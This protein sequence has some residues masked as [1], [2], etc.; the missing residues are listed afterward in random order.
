MQIHYLSYP[1]SKTIPVYGGSAS[2]ELIH[3]KVI[4]NGD[5]C[6]TW[7]FCLENHWGTHVDCPAHFFLKGKHVSDFSC[8]FWLFKNPQVIQ[9]DAEPGQIIEARDL[10]EEIP[11]Q[12]DL[13][14]FKSGW[15]QFRGQEIYSFQNPGLHPG[16]G[17]L[18]RKKYPDIRCI[19][20]DWVSVSSYQHRELGREAHRAFLNNSTT[21]QPVMIIEDMDLSKN[22]N[23]LF[24]VLVAP[25]L[26]E[27]IDSA[28]CTVIG[29]F[30][31]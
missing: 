21:S 7:R 31:D 2:P 15:G 30:K 28:P 17:T 19:G 10:P 20:M 9:I 16:L 6:N 24:E 14:L 26:I 3:L 29:F 4:D 11:P 25:I 27:T 22:L 1:I 8:D 23:N 12:T 13:L 18:L 5:S